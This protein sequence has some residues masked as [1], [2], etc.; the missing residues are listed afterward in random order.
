MSLW[1]AIKKGLGMFT[2]AAPLVAGFGGAGFTGGS[3][4]L[5]LI[6]TGL[7]AATSLYSAIKGDESAK[8]PSFAPPAATPIEGPKGPP[9][10]PT[11]FK[12]PTGS[13]NKPMF[14]NYGGGLS[15]LQ[16]RAAIATGALQGG[17]EYRDPQTT[18]YYKYLTQRD[19]IGDS[20]A[21]AGFENILPV[22]QDYIKKI[23][24]QEIR[25]NDTRGFLAALT[26]N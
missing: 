8:Q 4:L 10:D 11:S 15:P 6:A 12:R 26:R 19:L 22:E 17:S 3:S 2:Q 7:T 14:L 1:G 13:V 25:S 23:L 5:P 18:N 16:E 20:G 9:P 21:L 24:G